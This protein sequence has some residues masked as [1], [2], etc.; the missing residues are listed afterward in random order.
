[1]HVNCLGLL[2]FNNN[3]Y[4]IVNTWINNLSKNLK[5]FRDRVEFKPLLTVVPIEVFLKY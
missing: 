5:Y 1:M 4:N 2:L 3:L